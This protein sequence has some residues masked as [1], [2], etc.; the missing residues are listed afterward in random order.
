MKIILT[1]ILFISGFG[2]KLI[3]L[4]ASILIIYSCKKDDPIYPEYK[5]SN[6]ESSGI[7]AGLYLDHGVWDACKISTQS[8]LA[9]MNCNYTILN[10]DSILNGSLNHYNLFIMPGGDM[11]EYSNTL[12]STGMNNIREFVSSGGG[13]IG[14][15]GGSYFAASKIVWRGWAN[16]PR[17]YLT[18]SGGS[19]RSVRSAPSPEARNIRPSLPGTPPPVICATP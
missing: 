1:G 14:I 9:E 17:Q 6:K 19:N 10:K 4:I 11:W 18:I 2:Y 3:Y 15:C 16:E 12:T 5:L 13:Y 8:M 7:K